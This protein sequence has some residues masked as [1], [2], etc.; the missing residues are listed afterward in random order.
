MRLTA[1][2]A[3]V[4]S[5]LSLFVLP[6][7]PS[8]A[9]TIRVGVTSGPHAQIVEAL[10]P[11]AKAKG[12]D[13]KVIEFSDG[14][15]IDAATDEGELDAN[16]FQHTPY[17]DQQ[18]HDRGLDIVSVARTVLL[19]IAG[20]SRKYKSV[21][22]LPKGAKIAIPNDPTNAG[23]SLKLLE[24]GGLLKLT[25]GVGFNATVLDIVENP[26]AVKVI[27]LEATQVPRSLE[28]VDFAV[29]NTNFAIQVGLDPIKDSL[30]RESE[31]SEYFCLI[32]VARK[33]AGK[34]WVKTL[35]DSYRSPEVKTF[36]ASTFKGSILPGW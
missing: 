28:D 36:V 34:P 3:C 25:P 32:G 20:Y 24:A 9:E 11:V 18:N 15:M 17:L 5:A 16:A 33:N 13:V 6:A 31:Q 21:T 22:D 23:R 30:L 8:R 12:L 1:G 7:G 2:L 14:T 27:E 29:I 10:V 35:V 4:V 19:P 26:K